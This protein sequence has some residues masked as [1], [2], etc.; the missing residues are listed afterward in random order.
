VDDPKPIFRLK[1]AT[2]T[3]APGKT[4]VVDYNSSSY[5]LWAG[6]PGLYSLSARYQPYWRVDDPT[7]AC[8][9][10]GPDGFVQL[11]VLKPGPIKLSFDVSPGSAAGAV[12]GRSSYC[13][14]PPS[15]PAS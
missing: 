7:A 10:R 2:T 5:N 8:V 13:V 4:E 14:L 11:Q 6:T 9:M 3:G 12:A 15:A 1:A